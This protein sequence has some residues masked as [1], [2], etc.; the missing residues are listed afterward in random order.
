MVQPY[1]PL[2]SAEEAA[3]TLGVPK[4][5]IYELMNMGQ[6]PYLI[7]KGKSMKGSRKIRGSDLEKFIESYKAEI[8]V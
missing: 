6:I 8:P 5:L 4:N 2:Y 3:E 7:I 1:R